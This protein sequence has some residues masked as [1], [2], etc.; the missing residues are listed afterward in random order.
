MLLFWEYPSATGLLHSA[1]LKGSGDGDGEVSLCLVLTFSILPLNIIFVLGLLVD[2][3]SRFFFWQLKN[4]SFLI[5]LRF[6]HDKNKTLKPSKA[7]RMLEASLVMG[8]LWRPHLG[9]GQGEILDCQNITKDVKQWYF[10]LK[11]N[12]KR[13]TQNKKVLSPMDAEFYW[14]FPPLINMFPFSNLWLCSVIQTYFKYL[15]DLL[16]II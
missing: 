12:R 13:S 1:A 4:F 16:C 8:E 7:L 11:S 15:T 10:I 14:N 9:W 3:F 5:L 6:C 2:F